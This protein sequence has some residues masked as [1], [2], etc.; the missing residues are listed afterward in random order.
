MT[1]PFLRGAGLRG[2]GLAFMIAAC[3][4]SPSAQRVALPGGEAGI[5]FDDLRYS[6]ALHRVL[7]PA[8]RTGTLALVDP[9][10]LAITSISGFGTVAGYS[11]DHDDGP[12]SV[13][14]GN[15][16]LYVTDRTTGKIDVV[17]PAARRIVASA[18]LAAGPDYVRFV[19]ATNELWVTEPSADQL[20]ILKLGRDPAAAPV[21]VAVIA[22]TNGPESMVID[23][24]RGRAYT[25]R[26]QKTTVAIDLVRRAV[27]GEWPNGCAASRGI[28]LDEER[29]FLFASC[30]D[31]TT[32]VLD[33][34]NSGRIVSTLARG[35]GFDVIGYAPQ[36][37]QRGPRVR[38]HPLRGRRRRRARLV[39][40]P[41]PRQRLA[42]DGPRRPP[43]PHGALAHV[44][45]GDGSAPGL[46]RR[47]GTAS[48]NCWLDEKLWSD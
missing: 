42:R 29:G 23:N 32:S 34:G 45:G 7:V 21:H 22:V 24:K 37:H 38:Q 5:G 15:G 19:K 46:Q 4:S 18:P 14:E 48:V 31:G 3:A 6:P 33:V 13:D 9:D 16:V 27:V 8:G 36:L 44:Q 41:A 40:R 26:W 47:T 10:T 1:A 43:R 17:D 28:A 12:T 30:S 35:S 20:E 11:G 2:V 25:H 39:V